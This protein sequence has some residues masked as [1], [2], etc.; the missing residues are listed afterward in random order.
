MFYD[1]IEIGTS[2]FNTLIQRANN[3]VFGLSIEPIDSYLNNLPNPLNCTK[4]N[5]AISNFDG[6]SIVYFMT[7]ADIIKHGLPLWV[8]GCNSI[9]QPH[10]SVTGL[11]RHKNLDPNLLLEK[12]IPTYRLLTI[13]EKYNVEGLYYLKVDTEGHDFTILD[14]F[15]NRSSPK[16]WPH[17]LSFESNVLSNNH[18]IHML[19]AKLITIGYDIISCKTGGGDTN[20]SLKLNIKRLKN[21]GVI[22]C[23][24]PGYFLRGY[25]DGYNPNNLPHGNNYNDA[26]DFC[27][28][29]NM[30][31]V[32]FQYGRFE[33][34]KGDYLN[35]HRE[36]REVKSWCLVE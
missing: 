32:T 22:S 16:Q 31:G 34:R 33:V 14:D 25:P 13:F 11:L 3:S 20:T 21:R 12:E 26:M 15:F 2:N 36:S 18:D 17:Q 4:I 10:P 6:K 5:A 24:M 35:E 1:F 7:I 8:R 27:I 28:K 23:E 29:N 30:S 19:I 9:G